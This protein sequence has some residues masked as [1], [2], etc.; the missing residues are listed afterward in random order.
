VCDPDAQAELEKPLDALRQ[1]HPD[2]LS[3]AIAMA[4]LAFKSNEPEP[5][6]RSLV[7]LG[8]LVEKTPLDPLAEGVRANSR[9]R[10][11]AAAQIPLWL[12]ARACR[13]HQS[14]AMRAHGE[15]F[16]TRALEAARRQDDRLWLLAMMR[17]QGQ[18]AF[19][20]S[21]RA[22]ASA[23]WTRM[24]DLVVTPPR[25]KTKRAAAAGPGAG[26]PGSRPSSG[27]ASQPAPAQ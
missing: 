16:A 6:E 18:T 13:G 5:M 23:A 10:A 9:E 11:Q 24:L 21:D 14:P 22:S 27:P 17:E 3:V 19:D 7:R 26:V 25:A 20:Q 12:V 15:R 1:T 8:E 4:L 2:D